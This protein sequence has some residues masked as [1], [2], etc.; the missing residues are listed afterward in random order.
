MALKT[1]HGYD[2]RK[3]RWSHRTRPPVKKVAGPQQ[4]EKGQH[5]SSGQEEPANSRNWSTSLEREKEH[6]EE[7]SKSERAECTAQTMQ[8]LSIYSSR[9]NEEASKGRGCVTLLVALAKVCNFKKNWSRLIVWGMLAKFIME[10]EIYNGRQFHGSWSE[11]L[12]LLT[13]CLGRPG[14]REQSGTGDRL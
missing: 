9:E 11:L 3:S 6:T 7:A 13:A 12:G 10:G 2:G 5:K 8:E 4:A 1:T 14:S